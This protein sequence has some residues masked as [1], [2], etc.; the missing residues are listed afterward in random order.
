[1]F[2]PHPTDGASR[3]QE[4]NIAVQIEVAIGFDSGEPAPAWLSH[5]QSVSLTL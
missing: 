2:C 1:M 5:F 4:K 3:L